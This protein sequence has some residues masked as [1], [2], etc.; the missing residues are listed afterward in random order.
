MIPAL[1][2]PNA[3]DALDTFMADAIRDVQDLY[4]MDGETAFRR[5]SGIVETFDTD[6]YFAGGQR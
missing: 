1:W 2:N 6:L 5:R 4:F 3:D